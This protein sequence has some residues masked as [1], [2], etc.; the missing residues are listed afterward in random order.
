VISLRY[1]L[2]ILLILCGRE[3]AG[4]VPSLGLSNA[5]L[6]I[7]GLTMGFA[8]L[9][10]SLAYRL[11]RRAVA[12]GRSDIDSVHEAFVA[13][14]LTIER[15]WCVVLPLMLLATGWF[16]WTHQL[17]ELGWPQ[18]LALLTCFLPAIVFVILV[19]LTAAQLDQLCSDSHGC[20]H[21]STASQDPVLRNPVLSCRVSGDSIDTKIQSGI[22]DDWLAQWLIRLRLG[23][24]A[25]LLTCL[26]PVFIL[27]TISD[28]G[29]WAEVLLGPHFGWIKVPLAMGLVAGFIAIFPLLL[30]RWSNGQQLPAELEYR[31]STIASK[32]GVRGV[33]PMLIPSQGRW[34]GAAIVGWFPGLRHLWLGDAIVSGLSP[35]QL[36]MVILHEL[37]HVQRMHFLWRIAPV[38]LA[39]FSGLIAWS[40]GNHLGFDQSLPLKFSV[41]ILSGLVLLMGMGQMARRCEMDADR[42]ACDLAKKAVEWG[43]WHC[44]A[45][46]L[47]SAL[48]LLLA[49][50]PSQASTWL[51]PSLAQRK[52]A[53]VLW[54]ATHNVQPSCI[55]SKAG[56]KT[57]HLGNL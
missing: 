35:R 12:H 34:A 52:T 3:L 48:S 20:N 32:V 9:T 4:Q 43:S 56:V 36:D 19:E 29:D 41:G 50:T 46:E 40:A 13:H 30:T 16:S 15:W 26:F 53:L 1:F 10:K 54:K 47:S 11:V 28:F 7:M 51:H 33:R 24:L 14:R 37:A 44:P 23:D 38:A 55:A 8:L 31:I 27:A 45:Q 17:H 25:G 22:H 39:L 6:S 2:L 49:E 5:L 21:A 18:S 57:K 42:E